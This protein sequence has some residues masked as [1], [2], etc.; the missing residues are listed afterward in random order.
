MRIT[1]IKLSALPVVFL[2]AGLLVAACS[3]GTGSGTTTSSAAPSTAVSSIAA[4][5]PAAIRSH[6]TLI[7]AADATYAPNEFIGSDGH[8]VEIGRASCRERV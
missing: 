1:Q 2:T 3:S 7:V 6:G 4:Q 5:V 8:T